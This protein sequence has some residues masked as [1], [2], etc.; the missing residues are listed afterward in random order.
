MTEQ[1]NSILREIPP[2]ASLLEVEDLVMISELF[3]SLD[4]GDAAYGVGGTTLAK[5]LHRKR[6]HLI[7]LYDQRIWSCY[8]TINP[9]SGEDRVIPTAKDRT[10]AEFMALMAS[11][12]RK[13]LTDQLPAWRGVL[14]AN[15]PE[16]PISLL[17]CFDIVAWK[18]GGTSTAPVD[19][20]IDWDESTQ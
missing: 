10:W 5:V 9:T 15:V 14:E 4:N 12:I 20:A 7:P 2:N 16:S 13:D 18:C 8:C 1:L 6:P 17:R 3:A 11:A 19:A